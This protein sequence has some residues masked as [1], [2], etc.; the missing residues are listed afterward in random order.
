MIARLW[1]K[2]A[3]TNCHFHNVTPYSFH[4]VTPSIVIIWTLAL[5]QSSSIWWVFEFNTTSINMEFIKQIH[6][7]PCNVLAHQTV[8]RNRRLFPSIWNYCRFSAEVHDSVI[9]KITMLLASNHHEYSNYSCMDTTPTSST[10]RHIPYP[11]SSL[12][13]VLSCATIIPQ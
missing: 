8:S 10:M 4:D 3:G 11:P 5:I 13:N 1:C 2:S 12:S 7:F 9:M 6:R